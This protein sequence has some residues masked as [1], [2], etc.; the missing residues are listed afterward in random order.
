MGRRL[1]ALA[2][3]AALAGGAAGCGGS[4]AEDLAD[5]GALREC[6]AEAGLAIEAPGLSASA[7]LGSAAVD[8][9][10]RTAGGTAVDVVVLGTARKAERT[11][12]DIAA[13]RAGF[14]G[15]GGEVLAERNAIAVFDADPGEEGRRAV[16][17]CLTGG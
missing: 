13:A 11:A 5:E 15:G 14:G 1:T 9:R 8:F 12:A 2:A 3:S 4:D 6:L 7:G 16:E 17:D 10:A